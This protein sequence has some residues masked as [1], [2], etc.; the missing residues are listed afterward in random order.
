VATV[1]RRVG[2]RSNERLFIFEHDYGDR[3][4]LLDFVLSASKQ[5]SRDKLIGFG[6]AVNNNVY[7]L[8]CFVFMNFR[9]SVKVFERWLIANYPSKVPVPNTF[10]SDFILDA[11]KRGYNIATFV[12]G[13]DETTELA[14]NGYGDGFPF[15]WPGRDEL[16]RNWPTRS[17]RRL[18]HVFLCH[19]SKDKPVVDKVF[20]E[21]QRL[22]VRA[23]YDKYEIAVGDDIVA[24]IDAGLADASCGLIVLSRN[25]IKTDARWPGVERSVLAEAEIAGTSKL[26]CLN[27]DL[28]KNE[29]PPIL[30]RLRYQDIREAGAITKIA[31]AVKRALVGSDAVG[32][33]S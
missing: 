27:V 1:E 30:R 24:K 8:Q 13:R 25:A 2:L 23:W 17:Y 11:G 9:G 22:E 26:L 10:I 3:A 28:E 5:F 6:I 12:E 32:P 7:D 14:I 29:I 4:G 15:I 20:R 33:L 18:G 21:L 19:S 31:L 16:T